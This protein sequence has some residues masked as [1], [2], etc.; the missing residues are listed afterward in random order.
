MRTFVE[1]YH[2]FRNLILYGIIGSFTS[3]L[4]FCVFTILTY[5]VG[6]FYII[7]NCISVI[8]GITTSFLLNRAYNFKIKDHTKR[9]FFIFLS[10][11]LLGLFLSN[12]IL[13]IGI[14]I[15]KGNEF[16]V[17]LASIFMVVGFQFLLNKF[18]TFKQ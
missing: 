1:V 5:K 11:G 17:K 16:I 13:Y 2:R 4:D 6:I 12:F 9:R 18:I 15:L 14:D 8:I 10:I 3:F 7:S